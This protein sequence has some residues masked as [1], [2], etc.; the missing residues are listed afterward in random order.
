MRNSLSMTLVRVF[1]ARATTDWWRFFLQNLTLCFITDKK[2]DVVN[3]N[4]VGVKRMAQSIQKS[5]DKITKTI[6]PKTKSSTLEFPLKDDDE[7]DIVEEFSKTENGGVEL[8]EKFSTWSNKSAYELFRTA[9]NNLFLHTCHYTW[10][11][12]T[13]YN[14][15][16]EV[17][18]KP[19]AELH[20]ISILLGKLRY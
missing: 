6:K 4:L 16:H 13:A 7:L 11:G 3:Y 20:L 8:Q 1:E 18:A 12:R 5:M 15:L 10:S 19:A 17:V 14:A 9:V 2:L